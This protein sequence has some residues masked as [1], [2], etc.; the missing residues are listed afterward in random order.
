[1]MADDV[2][3]FETFFACVCDIPKISVRSIFDI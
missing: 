3:D 1:M 2:N